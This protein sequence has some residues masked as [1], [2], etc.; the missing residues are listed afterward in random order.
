MVVVIMGILMTFSIKLATTFQNRATLSSTRDR[1]Q[2]IEE[3]LRT[4]LAANGRLPCPASPVASP[5]TGVENP[6]PINPV[7]PCTTNPGIVPYATLGLARDAALD[8]W[9]RFFVYEVADS[10]CASNNWTSVTLFPSGSSGVKTYHDGKTGCITVV[11]NPQGDADTTNDLTRT[12][13]VAVVVSNGANGFGGVTTKGQVVPFDAGD[14]TNFRE[15]NNIPTH[16]AKVTNTYQAEPINLSGFDDL[17]M[18]ISKDG[19]LTPLKRDGTITSIASI[20]RDY[21]AANIA[22]SSCVLTYPATPGATLSPAAPQVNA[23][24][25]TLSLTYGG[26]TVS[27]SINAVDVGCGSGLSYI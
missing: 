18:E 11:D 15:Q 10:T 20:M 5:I 27:K 13:I 22:V 21:L 16:P 25:V 24:S 4:Y 12:G 17:V 6:L 2:T 1:Q 3:T 19:L 9:D 26:V 8:G 14:T 7:A 23:A